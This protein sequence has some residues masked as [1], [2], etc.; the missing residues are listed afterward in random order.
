MLSEEWLLSQRRQYRRYKTHKNPG[1]GSLVNQVSGAIAITPGA[2]AVGS[3][4]LTAVSGVRRSYAGQ[5]RSE[6]GFPGTR[7]PGH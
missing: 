6:M 1:E 7:A 3:G 2:V 4:Y 5:L